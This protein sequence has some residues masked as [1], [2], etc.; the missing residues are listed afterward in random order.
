MKPL[1]QLIDEM[2]KPVDFYTGSKNTDPVDKCVLVKDS[3]PNIVRMMQINLERRSYEVESAKTSEEVFARL[4]RRR[5]DLLVTDVSP[6]MDGLDLLKTIRSD[7]TLAD[8][9]ILL[10]WSKAADRED[11]D[12]DF[13][14][15]CGASRVLA[16]PF[17]PREFVYIVGQ[18]L[19]ST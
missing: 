14:L 7:T 19:S 10:T 13:L 18:M 15:R 3:W 8:L 12:L 2:T 11:P 6:K 17:N 16:K 9:P 4:K 5:H 1:K